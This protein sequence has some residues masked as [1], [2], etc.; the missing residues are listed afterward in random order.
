M[1]DM[2]KATAVAP[3]KST[4]DFWHIY[5]VFLENSTSSSTSFLENSTLFLLICH[6]E[7]Q[8]SAWEF[9]SACPMPFR[10]IKIKQGA[11]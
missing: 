6:W 8:K 3:L 4:K 11:S 2:G 1:Q 10:K 9:F 5:G 7:F